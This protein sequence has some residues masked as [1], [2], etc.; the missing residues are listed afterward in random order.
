[1]NDTSFTIK[2]TAEK[3]HTSPRTVW[4]WIKHGYK[5]IYLGAQKEGWGWRITQEALR[6]FRYKCTQKSFE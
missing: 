5:G 1:M 2:Q 6:T 3:T 4:R